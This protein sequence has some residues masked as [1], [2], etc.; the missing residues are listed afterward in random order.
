MIQIEIE[1]SVSAD[2]TIY[3]WHPAANGHSPVIVESINVYQPAPPLPPT[4]RPNPAVEMGRRIT[5]R[6]IAGWVL[7]LGLA[8]AI[9]LLVSEVGL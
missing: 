5:P 8:V 7:G 4:T 9:G 3:R 2:G 1:I 6:E